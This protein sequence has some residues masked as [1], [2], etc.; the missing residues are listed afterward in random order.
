MTTRRP[1]QTPPV[2]VTGIFAVLMWL[3]SLFT[4]NLDLPLSLRIAVALA[5][6]AMGFSVIAFAVKGF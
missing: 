1:L 2:A 3:V 5:L 6:T 4:P